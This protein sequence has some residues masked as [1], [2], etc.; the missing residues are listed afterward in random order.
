[1]KYLN[2]TMITSWEK[3]QGFVSNLDQTITTNL[4][5]CSSAQVDMECHESPL[6]SHHM[7]G[8]DVQEAP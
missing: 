3:A 2:N 4:R 6:L 1:M 7:H 5:E 8:V